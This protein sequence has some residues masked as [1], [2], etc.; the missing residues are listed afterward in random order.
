MALFN[1]P[2]R[3][4]SIGVRRSKSMV[5]G[6]SAALGEGIT[7]PIQYNIGGT[8]F[9]SAF[10][11][12]LPKDEV[13]KNRLYRRIYQYDSVSGAAVDLMALLPFSDM[14]LAGVEDSA[15]MQVYQDTIEHLNTQTLVPQMATEFLIIG[16]LIGT[17]VFNDNL[18]IFTDIITQ[19][20]DY[21]L[22]EAI[23][24]QG[25]D[26]K[27]DLRVAPDFRK[28]L[29]S[30]DPRDMSARSELPEKLQRKL[31]SG[32]IAL[33]PMTTM[34]L[35]RKTFP[36]DTGTSYLSR[37]VPFFILEQLLLEGTIQGAQRRQRA[38]LH[39]QA[40]SEDWEPD[41]TQLE[42]LIEMFVAADLDPIGSVV[43]TKRD[44]DVGEVRAGGDFW[45]VTDE[46]DSLTQA[47]MRSLGINE[48]FL[49][50]DATYN[51]VTG[52]TIIE[53]RELGPVE[54]GKVAIDRGIDESLEKEQVVNFDVEVAGLKGWEQ[55]SKIV[56]Q[57]KAPCIRIEIEDDYEIT[58]TTDHPILTS[59]NELTLTPAYMLRVGDWVIVARDHRGLKQGVKALP[60][61]KIKNM[62]S[63]PVYDLSM[64]KRTSHIFIGNGIYQRQTMEAALSVFIETL[65]AFRFFVTQRVF[66][67]KLFPILARVHR[68]IKR[69]QSELDHN[70]RITGHARDIPVKDL[71]IPEIQWHKQLAPSYDESYFSILS[72]V[73]EQGLPI[74]LRVWAAAGG[75]SI[76]KLL[77]GLDDDLQVRKK[78]G[79][80]KQKMKELPGAGEGDEEEAWGSGNGDGKKTPRIRRKERAMQVI[81]N[82]GRA[83]NSENA[84][85]EATRLLELT[86]R[87]DRLPAS[88]IVLGDYS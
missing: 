55:N 56:Y 31:L 14:S 22:T 4:G 86:G 21:C 83:A 41:A 77:D 81:G 6:S 40:G 15:V 36:K 13:G 71:I 7:Q 26:P 57:G 61:T 9:E 63:Q 49:T 74:P 8:G 58:C 39:I 72:S 80:Y 16:K 67:Y 62:G 46:W 85:K 84:K 64:A 78:L 69:K 27:V 66:Y 82:A 60:I 73:Q 38:I 65:R 42:E 5:T 75:F 12:I 20:P 30:R 29:T 11:N 2:Q 43:A 53:T 28:F 1:L 23:P 35:A 51:C 3:K 19:D 59:Y 24:L 76:E 18:G 33:D 48:A 52:D 47:K 10:D 37:V 25:Y 68:F 70:I 34:Y 79:E 54:I 88:K 50:G 17:L 44:V 32:K 87:N 45:K